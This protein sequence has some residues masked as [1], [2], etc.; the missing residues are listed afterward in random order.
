MGVM[1]ATAEDYS[2]VLHGLRP[3]G[4]AMAGEDAV[5]AGLAP[6]FARAHNRLADLVL[7]SD[8]RTTY[9]LLTEWERAFGL[10]DGCVDISD[11]LVARI[12]A[13]VARVR[14][15]GSPTPQYFIDL[16]ATVGY[17][18]TITELQPHTVDSPVDYPLY[19]E[20]IRYVWQVNST[21]NTIT[22]ADVNSTVETPLASWG[23]SILECVITRAKPAHTHV[24]FSYSDP[25]DLEPY[26]R[27]TEDGEIRIT[28]HYEARLT[29]Y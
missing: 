27:L 13:L 19:A 4:P 28:E 22:Y 15:A 8:P 26:V 10:P 23:N 6:E 14:G 16:A 3:P 7:E 25:V 12:N 18:I 29:E 1:T 5:L 9:E 11:D 20:D 2:E 24:Q 17:D 21:L